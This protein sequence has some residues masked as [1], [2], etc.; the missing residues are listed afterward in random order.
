MLHKVP[1]A[2]SSILRGLIKR[3]VLF[4]LCLQ[5]AFFCS[6]SLAFETLSGKQL[7]TDC[8]ITLWEIKQPHTNLLREFPIGECPGYIQGAIDQ[9]EL[10]LVSTF[11]KKALPIIQSTNYE[12][13]DITTTQ[14]VKM[15]TNYLQNHPKQLKLT[16]ALAVYQTIIL[17]FTNSKFLAHDKQRG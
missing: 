16:A 15:V 6:S 5:S 1:R 12:M 4:T 8:Q 3:I 10:F 17:N 9:Y 13:K 7:L 2:M 11:G 14:L